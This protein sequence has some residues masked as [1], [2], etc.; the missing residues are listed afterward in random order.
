[1]RR[2]LIHRRGAAAGGDKLAEFT[3]TTASHKKTGC[4]LHLAAESVSTRVQSTE[5]IRIRVTPGVTLNDCVI[6]VGYRLRARSS[7]G[8]REVL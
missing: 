4:R 3:Q 7:Y 5:C 8:A 6:G 1:M 2:G